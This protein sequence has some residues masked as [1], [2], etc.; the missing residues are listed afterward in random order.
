MGHAG[1]W[2]RAFEGDVGQ[3]VAWVA[4]VYKILAQINRL[5]KWFGV[6]KKFSVGIKF[7]EGTKLG[8][9]QK[10]YVG[11]NTQERT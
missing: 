9:R 5:L 1:A 11:R 3:I 6:G 2:V 8:V 4:W 10:F 7:G